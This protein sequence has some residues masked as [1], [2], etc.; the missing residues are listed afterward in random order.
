M[1]SMCPNSAFQK[2]WISL[3]P[4]SHSRLPTS[5]EAEPCVGK[6]II[7]NTV[8]FWWMVFYVIKIEKIIIKK[9]ILKG[10]AWTFGNVFLL[11]VWLNTFGFLRIIISGQKVKG[12]RKSA[13]NFK[14]A[15]ISL[16]ADLIA[17][18]R[19]KMRL[20]SVPVCLQR[21]ILQV[22]LI[23]ELR[24]LFLWNCL[25]GFSGSNVIFSLNG[26]NML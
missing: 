11:L 23:C 18:M 1:W 20:F 4:S 24:F 13:T 10:C 14:I 19:L 6:M 2:C 3:F 17:K 22:Y 9:Y 8:F 26:I 7:L 15:F 5:G 25:N 21:H 16:N 12:V